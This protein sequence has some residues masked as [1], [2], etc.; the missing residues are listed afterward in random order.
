MDLDAYPG[1][2][3]TIRLLASWDVGIEEDLR[4]NNP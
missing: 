4:Q 2:K 3:Q 1:S